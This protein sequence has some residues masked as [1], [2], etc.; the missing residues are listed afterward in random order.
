MSDQDLQLMALG[1]ALV[2][3]VGALGV[4]GIAAWFRS[5]RYRR[6]LRVRWLMAGW[7]A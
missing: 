6:V 7:V 5:E 3:S 1:L 2:G 4:A